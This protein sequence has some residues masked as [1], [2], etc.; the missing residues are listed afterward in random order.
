ML[1]NGPYADGQLRDLENIH[2]TGTQNLGTVTVG[3]NC[4]LSPGENNTPDTRFENQL[5]A[6]NR[7]G[8]PSRTGLQ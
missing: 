1:I 7:P 3:E 4:R 6:W 5:R 8:R 2:S